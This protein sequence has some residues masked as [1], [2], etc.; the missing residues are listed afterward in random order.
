M[1]A[2]TAPAL[3]DEHI[4]APLAGARLLVVEDDAP[5]RELLLRRLARDGAQA[6]G[7]AD[8]PSALALLARETFDAVLLDI[9]LPGMDGLQVLRA[10]R[11]DHGPQTLPVLMV[12]AFSEQQRLAEAMEA[13][14][15]DFLNKPIDYRLVRPRLRVRLD[16][17]RSAREL[18][19]LQQRQALVL[20]ASND[21]IWEL[22]ATTGQIDHSPSWN[23]LLGLAPEAAPT[24][25]D[26]WL[27]RIHP[28]D[29]QTTREQFEA[30]LADPTQDAFRLQ[31]RMRRGDGDYT[32]IETRGAAL[33]DGQGRC[34]RLAGTHTDISALRYVNPA[35]QLPNLL[36][37]TDRIAVW[38]EQHPGAEHALIQ[39]DLRNLESQTDARA[40][41]TLGRVV[42]TLAESLRPLLEPGDLI[43]NGTLSNLLM[44]F[45]PRA[46]DPTEQYRLA[47][48]LLQ[49]L[50]SGTDAPGGQRLAANALA[51]L[52]HSRDEAAAPPEAAAEAVNA[53]TLSAHER[54]LQVL[55]FTAE[56]Q[57][58]EDLRRTLSTEL[59]AAVADE[60]IEPWWQP[61]LYA[62]GRIAGFEALARWQRAEGSRI[63]P[64]VFVPLA[65]R[66]GLLAEMTAQ[67]LDKSLAA[68]ARWRN[69]GL[70]DTDV[71]MSVNFSSQSLSDPDFAL[72]LMAAV[73]AHELPPEALCVEVTES[74]AADPNVNLLQIV[75]E[76]C[77][78]GLRVALDDFGTGYSSL[79][80]L[81]RQAF[82]TIK[83]DQSFVRNMLDQPRLLQ[84][85]R[86]MVA[87]ARALGLKLVAEGVETAAH[88]Q[89]LCA[90]GVDR[91][92]GF[93]YARAMPEAEVIEWLQ[94]RA[95]TF[96]AARARLYPGSGQ[97]FGA[98]TET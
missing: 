21:G 31:Y 36:R 30:F 8:G 73:A 60:Q 79:S 7:A 44:V 81:N 95:A 52:W 40:G 90:E 35:T 83:I 58:Q 16:L 68:L 72:T 56:L 23:R 74:D 24:D 17:A 59:H 20:R 76:L 27:A 45:L 10:I 98:G 71:Y 48:R 9:G 64:A 67:V 18:Q 4:D 37:L 19:R 25:V 57:A 3:L 84:M 29:A 63:S 46:I 62:D 22:D 2:P 14:A 80:Q 93:L 91:L 39:L 94:Q 78:R 47:R 89:A 33:R 1:D 97:D 15:N 70:V 5:S 85:I 75:S 32:W 65:T 54:G 49:R 88:E 87:M 11:R 66:A 13:G 50:K 77:E 28:A 96:A 55:R 82:D 69:A 61:I 42:F 92:Q 41:L 34:L 38:R 43:A 53:A 12:T 86:A 6:Q 51:G 26:G